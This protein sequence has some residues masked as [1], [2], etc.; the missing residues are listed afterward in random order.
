M[1]DCVNIIIA[2]EYYVEYYVDKKHVSNGK[3]LIIMTIYE[4]E[5]HIPK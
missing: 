3:A 5:F 1:C 4:K 2:N